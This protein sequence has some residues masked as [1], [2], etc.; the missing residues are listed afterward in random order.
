MDKKTFD[1]LNIGDV[2]VLRNDDD[3]YTKIDSWTRNYLFGWMK[4]HTTNAIV[5][6]I[7]KTCFHNHLYVEVLTIHGKFKLKVGEW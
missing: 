4:V 2:I 3:F 7:G 5:C 6:K 1:K